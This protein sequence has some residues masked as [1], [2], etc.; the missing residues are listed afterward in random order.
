MDLLHLVDRLEELVASAQKMPI[1][2]RAIVDRRRLLDIVD[3]M[4]VVIPQEVRDAQEIVA[5]HEALKREAQ[6]EARMIVARAEEEAVRLVE[7]HTITNAARVRAVELAKSA[8]DRLQLRVEEANADIRERMDESRRLARQQMAH[9]DAY[10]AELLARLERQLQAFTRSVRSGL[11][12]LGTDDSV[13]PG[14]PSAADA[15]EIPDVLEASFEAK[16]VSPAA[17]D[18]SR[19]RNERYETSDED[20]STR[21]A[22]L[23]APGPI[24]LHASPPGRPLPVDT[25]LENLLRSHSERRSLPGRNAQ[26]TVIRP[27]P[28]QRPD[29]GGVIDDYSLPPLDDEP[30]L[31]VPGRDT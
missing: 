24:P 16:V 12:Q 10:A 3:Q 14:Q 19:A 8:E 17:D 11:S 6:E 25:E 29:A 31:H 20:E 4:R 7:E 26:P 5:G 18:L 27:R 22:E 23:V 30:D 21:R 2:N 28:G 13:A 1:G 9:A 15:P